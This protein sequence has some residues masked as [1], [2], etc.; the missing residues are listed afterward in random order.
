LMALMASAED[1]I[2]RDLNGSE[3]PNSVP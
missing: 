2:Q 1:T 3:F